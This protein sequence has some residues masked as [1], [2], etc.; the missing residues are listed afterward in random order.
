MNEIKEKTLCTK[1][2]SLFGKS[3]FN[4]YT[5]TDEL[6]SFAKNI[7]EN[8]P[9]SKVGGY[10]HSFVDDS[11]FIASKRFERFATKV[12]AELN[13]YVTKYFMFNNMEKLKT[14]QYNGKDPLYVMLRDGIMLD[15]GLC[16]M[17]I[18]QKNADFGKEIYSTQLL[19]HLYPCRHSPLNYYMTKII[20][21]YIQNNKADITA[22]EEELKE[23][24]KEQKAMSAKEQ[25]KQAIEAGVPLMGD[26]RKLFLGTNFVISHIP[27]INGI[28]RYFEEADE[29]VYE[30]VDI[31]TA[32]ELY[33]SCITQTLKLYIKR[34]IL[35][36][37]D[38][39]EVNWTTF[40][41]PETE[42]EIFALILDIAER[43]DREADNVMAHVIFPLV[44]EKI[45]DFISN[46]KQFKVNETEIRELKSQK[47]KAET[48][49]NKA[50]EKINK[51]TN[52]LERQKTETEN[53]KKALKEKEKEINGL[54]AEYKKKYETLN[55]TF[56]DLF[57][58]HT[59]LSEYVSML[60]EETDEETEDNEDITIP[61][62]IINKRFVFVNEKG[63]EGYIFNRKLKEIFPNSDVRYGVCDINAE[64]TDAVILLTK[65]LKHGTYWSMRDKYRDKG[66]PVLH[67]NKS[68]IS[69]II[70]TVVNETR[71]R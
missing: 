1:D 4:S 24:E 67:C 29:K 36:N 3:S 40:C 43:F 19:S 58:K 65:Y 15:I 14:Q 37:K 62:N 71:Y 11:D 47:E 30:G 55:N 23:A 60:E 44:S 50:E 48:E 68:S 20:S 63:K 42:E 39:S 18:E 57:N 10:F 2:F 38:I 66:I 59:E 54:N 51:L 64:T 61:E 12:N 21:E 35:F 41:K 27:V 7:H 25:L 53:I 16:F 9:K 33:F 69:G 34:K 8:M 26:T 32:S 17:R 28:E 22:F 52:E 46:D 5:V 56:L 70:D 49:Y 31:P 13:G 6:N 45:A